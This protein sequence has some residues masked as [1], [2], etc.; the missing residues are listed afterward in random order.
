MVKNISKYSFLENGGFWVDALF[1]LLSLFLLPRAGGIL[2]RLFAGSFQDDETSFLTIG[3]IIV[4]MFLLRWIALGLIGTGPRKEEDDPGFGLVW[5]LQLPTTLMGMAFLIIA[6]V[7]PLRESGIV[8]LTVGDVP[9]G[10]MGLSIIGIEAA[11]LYRLIGRK[12]D[13][14]HSIFTFVFSNSVLLGHLFL[15]QSF[16]HFGLSAIAQ[17][18]FDSITNLIFLIV[19]GA[20]MFAMFYIGPR[21]LLLFK[22]ENPVVTSVRMVIVF[23]FSVA[24]AVYWS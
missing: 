2:R 13:A 22:D 6:I 24:A 8:D 21:S 5:V 3:A 11:L 14:D 23:V 16:Y 20:V 9:I 12:A 7:I 10:L 4:S 18:A 19:L 15:W 17:H 1:L